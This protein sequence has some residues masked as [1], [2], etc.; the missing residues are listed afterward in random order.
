MIRREF[1][2]FVGVTI[3]SGSIPLSLL[4]QLP[5]KKKTIMPW[6]F[7]WYFFNTQKREVKFE[8][9]SKMDFK[10]FK[11][12][13]LKHADRI[14]KLYP[15]PETAEFPGRTVGWY[16]SWGPKKTYHDRG[17]A[18]GE[19]GTSDL[20]SCCHSLTPKAYSHFLETMELLRI[21]TAK[22]EKCLSDYDSLS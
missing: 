1:M 16:V 12:N 4:N 2:K 10:A 7:S 19:G 18:W 14:E 15:L 21:A 17:L 6:R 3:S 20:V 9:Y 22:G 5:E 13:I 8:S 11:K